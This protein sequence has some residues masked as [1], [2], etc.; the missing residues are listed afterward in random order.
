[1]TPWGTEFLTRRSSRSSWRPALPFMFRSPVEW[2][3]RSPLEQE[4]FTSWTQLRRNGDRSWVQLV[5]PSCSSGE[6]EH[7]STGERNIKGNAGRQLE[8]E[9]LLVRNSVPHGVIEGRPEIVG[10]LRKSRHQQALVWISNVVSEVEREARPQRVKVE[11]PQ[12]ESEAQLIRGGQRGQQGREIRAARLNAVVFNLVLQRKRQPT[13]RRPVGP[14]DCGV[15]GESVGRSKHL[16][17][18]QV[19][20]CPELQRKQAVDPRVLNRNVGATAQ[21]IQAPQIG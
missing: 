19:Q 11:D 8:R 2:C 7:H 5:N 16:L 12:W 4:G 18:H 20:L 1:M 6:R 15:A 14:S 10:H 13:K 3:S 17:G 9:D 21:C